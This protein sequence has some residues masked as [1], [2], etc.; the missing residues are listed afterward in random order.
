M[1]PSLEPCANAFFP[2]LCRKLF[3][4]QNTRFL[5]HINQ[6]SAR[7]IRKDTQIWMVM[8][9]CVLFVSSVGF[10]VYELCRRLQRAARWSSAPH[11][12]G[13]NSGEIGLR[14][15]GLS[16][17]AL[18]TSSHQIRRTIPPTML[19]IL[20]N[21]QKM[22]TRLG[23]TPAAAGTIAPS[24]IDWFASYSYTSCALAIVSWSLTKRI[25]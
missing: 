13:S 5:T 12:R 23:I 2:S 21:Q 15:A 8:A 7:E 16:Q 11:D 19:K 25:Q 4:K 10:L 20:P 9:G 3:S 14:P 1:L 18:R 17:Q 24:R 6:S 22:K